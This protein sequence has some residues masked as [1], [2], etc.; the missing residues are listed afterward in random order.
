MCFGVK[1]VLVL[2]EEG[3]FICSEMGKGATSDAEKCLFKAANV[4]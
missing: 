2:F 3:I 1:F 4:W